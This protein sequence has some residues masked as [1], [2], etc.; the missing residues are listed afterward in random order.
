MNGVLSP[1]LVL[2]SSSVHPPGVDG[3][4]VCAPLE[5]AVQGA[6]CLPGAEVCGL[7]PCVVLR[8]CGA[9]WNWGWKRKEGSW[10]RLPPTTSGLEL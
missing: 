3:A 8:P 9:E 5:G 7:F 1:R 10:V 4:L 2:I 6:A